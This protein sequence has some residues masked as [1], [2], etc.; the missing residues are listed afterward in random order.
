MNLIT[1]DWLYLTDGLVQGMALRYDD[2]GRILE[3]LPTEQADAGSLQKV[4]GVLSPGFV[5]V[6][7][8]LE[9]SHLKG[10]I[11]ENTGMVGFIG[12]LQ[13]VRNSV[14]EAAKAALILEAAQQMRDNGIVAVGD[15]C[16]GL[17]SLAAKEAVPEIRWHNFIEVFGMDAQ[18]ASSTLERAQELR[19]AFGSHRSTVTLHAPYSVS[20]ELRRQ[21]W[22]AAAA[23]EGPV[24]IHLME[25]GEEMELF[26]KQRGPFLDF[27]RAIGAEFQP[28]GHSHPLEYIATD[29]PR[30][31]DS[32]IWVHNTE[33]RMTDLHKA[34]N[35]SWSPFWYCLC[36]KANY[37]IHRTAPPAKVLAESVPGIVCLGTDSL[38]GNDSLDL[39]EEMK[40]LQ[41]YLP[42]SNAELVLAWGTICGAKALGMDKELGSFAVGKKP[43]ILQLSPFD[44]EKQLL[45]EATQVNRIV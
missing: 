36:P 1:A 26:R 35:L 22:A 7:C 20:P 2:S 30:D 38:A 43:G 33:M 37:Y 16:N 28:E 19:A 10:H 40:V 11:P 23:Q 42:G 24:S 8:H 45:T 18:R 3:I 17:D 6:H 39:L 5:N 21:G 14:P 44:D 34:Q 25:S 32:V 41:P 15:I 13:Q 9:L 12:A 4:T 31:L 27:F 29:M